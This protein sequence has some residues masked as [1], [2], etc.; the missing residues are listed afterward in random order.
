M[1][2]VILILA[3][4]AFT[5][6]ASTFVNTEEVHL[7]WNSWKSVHGKIYQKAEETARF[8][9]FVENYKKIIRYNAQDNGV[10][11]A[12]N[13]FSDLTSEEFK[14]I[15]TG[16]FVETNE[17][18]LRENTH[19]HIET[20]A[21]LGDIDWRTNGFVTESRT[22]VNVDHAGLSQ[23]LVSLKVSSLSHTVSFTISLNN[24]L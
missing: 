9:I 14:S 6:L 13:A 15:Y 19:A 4:L 24:K 16:A 11:L 10:K 21:I 8:A 17:N 18:I 22:K 1:Q 23:Q 20:D 5:G 12:L 3:L 7:L 2:K